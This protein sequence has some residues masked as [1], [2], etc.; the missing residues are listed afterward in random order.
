MKPC[1]FPA[2]GRPAVAHGLCNPHYQQHRR[3]G[4]LKPLKPQRDRYTGPHFELDRGGPG[5]R[6]DE[7]G[8]P[9]GFLPEGGD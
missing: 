9:V 1:S 6:Y 3:G 2:C 4:R 5:Y 8:W 7:R